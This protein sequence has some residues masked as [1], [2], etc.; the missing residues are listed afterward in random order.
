MFYYYPIA[1]LDPRYLPRIY[2]VVEMRKLINMQYLQSCNTILCLTVFFCVCVCM[3]V[4]IMQKPEEKARRILPRD[5]WHRRHISSHLLC[6][7]KLYS[8]Y[9]ALATKME[10]VPAESHMQTRRHHSERSL[11]SLMSHAHSSAVKCVFSWGSLAS[12]V[13]GGTSLSTGT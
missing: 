1:I 7:A 9:S 8:W 12:H 5:L 13:R 11:Q 2:F 6:I 10:Q 3:C 4:G